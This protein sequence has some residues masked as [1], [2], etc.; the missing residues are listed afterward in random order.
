MRRASARSRRADRLLFDKVEERD[1]DIVRRGPSHPAL[2]VPLSFLHR[3]YA[4]RAGRA[5][6]QVQQP[7]TSSMTRST[8]SPRILRMAS[9]R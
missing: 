2:D 7:I 8:F 5:A 3:Q 1:G 6:L 4:L 9:S